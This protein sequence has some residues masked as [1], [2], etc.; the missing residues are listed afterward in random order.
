MTIVW[1]RRSHFNFWKDFL[2][3][4]NERGMLFQLQ[5]DVVFISASEKYSLHVIIFFFLITSVR[6]LLFNYIC[7]PIRKLISDSHFASIL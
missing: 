2:I 5:F 7:E 6:Q 4:Q 1:S 3:L